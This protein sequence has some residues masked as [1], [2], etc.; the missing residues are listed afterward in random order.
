[1]ATKLVFGI[2][3]SL[4]EKLIPDLKQREEARE[5]LQQMDT[6]GELDQILGQIQVNKQ[7]AAHK[8]IFVAGWRPA[9]GWICA[10][11]MLY[12]FIVRP[13]L[14]PLLAKLGIGDLAVLD[15][16]QLSVVLTGLLG[17]GAMRSY[18]KVRGAAREK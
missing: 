10:I 1:M 11:A 4:L 3:E 15:W 13:I 18:E 2:V 5:K 16:D 9:I 17:L 14:S 7:E 6:K 8:S 12:H